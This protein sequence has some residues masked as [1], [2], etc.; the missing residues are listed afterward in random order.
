M[1]KKLSNKMEKQIREFVNYLTVE[2]GYSS[3]TVNAYQKNL[4]RYTNFMKN[5]NLTDLDNVSRENIVLYLASLKDEHLS[6]STIAQNIA[7]IRTFHKFLLREKFTSTLPT[8]ELELPKK[9]KTLPDVL[10]IEEV[11]MLLAQPSG[12]EPKKLRDKAIL[13]LLYGTG[14]RV[15]ELIALDL[16]DIDLELAFLRCYGKGS[17]ERMV[18][19]GSYAKQALSDYLQYGRPQLVRNL[20]LVAF[21][22]NTRGKRLS[23]QGCWLIVKGYASQAGLAKIYPH[24]LRHS[25][26]THL[27]EGG[28]DLRAVQKLLGH[29]FVSTTQI[30]THISRDHLWQVYLESHPRARDKNV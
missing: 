16:D 8:A 24:S 22:V 28:A 6:A 18:P 26:A 5:R 9:P 10:S 25:F 7:S 4:L 21:F 29:A 30:Y 23:R 15:S 20:S 11:E 27:L 3:N 12:L 14:L 1:G 2:R 17:K 19:L 13:E